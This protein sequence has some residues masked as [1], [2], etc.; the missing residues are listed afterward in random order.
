MFLCMQIASDDEKIRAHAEAHFGFAQ[1][2]QREEGESFL[3]ID[4]IT[5]KIIDSAFGIHK[6]LGPGLLES[7]YEVVL[8]INFDDSLF[9][10]GVK[11]IVNNYKSSASLREHV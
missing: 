3:D 7:V 5:G 11:R 1:Y 9:K 6:G 8:I 4:L 10:N 2:K